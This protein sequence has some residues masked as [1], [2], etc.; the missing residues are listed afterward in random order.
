M[1]AFQKRLD[2][3]TVYYI[4]YHFFVRGVVG[5]AAW[6]REVDKEEDTE[7]RLTTAQTEA[8]AMLQLENNYYACCVRPSWWLVERGW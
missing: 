3:P 5:E 2:I 4:F 6:R 1:Q 7:E 8:F